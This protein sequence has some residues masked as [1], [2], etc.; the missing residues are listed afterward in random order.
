MNILHL[1][2]GD[3]AVGELR[4]LAHHA[5]KAR[6][7]LTYPDMVR[8]PDCPREPLTS[9]PPPEYQPSSSESDGEEI[10][11]EH[12]IK[13]LTLLLEPDGSPRFHDS[14][15]DVE[16]LVL[17]CVLVERCTPGLD[18]SE[19]D[20]ASKI[21]EALRKDIG[22]SAKQLYKLEGQCKE[23]LEPTRETTEPK[24]GQRG[25]RPEAN[26][27]YWEFDEALQMAHQ[28]H[29]AGP[30]Q[31]SSFSSV[32][33]RKAEEAAIVS[34]ISKAAAGVLDDPLDSHDHRSAMSQQGGFHELA[35]LEHAVGLDTPSNVFLT[36]I[37]D[38]IAQARR[39]LAPK[40][41][42]PADIA[43]SP[44]QQP[45][46]TRRKRRGE[47]TTLDLETNHPAPKRRKLGP[48]RNKSNGKRQ[49]INPIPLPCLYCAE[50]DASL[51]RPHPRTD[52]NKPWVNPLMWS[53]NF[54][55]D[56]ATDVKTAD[57]FFELVTAEHGAQ[58]QIV[59]VG[60]GEGDGGGVKFMVDVTAGETRIVLVEMRS[61]FECFLGSVNGG[62]GGRR[63]ARFEAPVGV[64][65]KWEGGHL[66]EC[67]Y[68]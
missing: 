39:D 45:A 37:G 27:W 1:L 55:L 7:E 36:G 49:Y 61:V 53:F 31:F 44:A 23:L 42:K 18:Q 22:L 68:L 59:E 4:W 35:Q 41:N 26:W 38:K 62:R 48:P 67:K 46:P 28:Q 65:E 52:D 9:P 3:A 25:A 12:S 56:D 19:R 64:W 5:V 8:D 2:G 63:R 20:E 43:T 13:K 10:N 66:R 21:L 58:V 51:L 40:A 15:P 33:A 32:L 29:S 11:A 57:E 60:V 34:I 54:T 17:L 16:C 50:S 6:D 47:T 30:Q 14:P 24:V